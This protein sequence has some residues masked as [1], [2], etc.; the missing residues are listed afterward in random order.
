MKARIGSSVKLGLLIP[1]A[2]ILSG[3]AVGPRYQ[4]PSVAVPSNWMVDQGAGTAAGAPSVQWWKSFNDDEFS[5]LIERAVDANL[6]LKLAAARVTEARAETGI[7]RAGLL[8]SVNASASATRNRQRVIAVSSGSSASA[9]LVPIEFNN[10]Q[11]GFDA[12]WEL[13]L[14]G[15]VRRGLQAANADA[16]AAAEAR[17]DVLVTLLG[18]VGRSYIELRGFQLRSDIAEKNIGIQQ[19]T[20]HLTEARAKA[21]LATEL[22]VSRARAQLETTES[23]IPTLQSGIENSIHHLSVLLGEE[24]EALRAELLPVAPVPL[25]PPEVPTGMPSDLLERRP[26]IREMEAQV[27]AATARVG[28]AKADLFPRFL[29]LG[30][31]ARQASQLHDITLGMGNVFGAGPAISLPIFTGGRLRSQFHVQD[32]RLQQAAIGYRKVIL[33]ALEETED[34]LVN[35]SQEQKRRQRLEDAVKSNEEA[36]RL[37]SQTYRAGLTDFLSVLDAEREL[38]A[39]EDLLAQSRTAQAVNLIALYKAL[40][41]GWQSIP[42][43]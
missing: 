31:A 5:R 16:R 22:D 17:R 40:G 34:A 14:F 18:E 43:P 37:S 32:A 29:L 33:T 2:L 3:C 28:Q 1:F 35:Y 12:S 42:Q 9:K 36:V 39:N 13:D 24:P 19:D 4:R 27:M 15:S 6:D 7:A 20:L 26:D 8:P 38:Y 30:T 10:Y 21:G 41:G 25:L 11:G 23:I